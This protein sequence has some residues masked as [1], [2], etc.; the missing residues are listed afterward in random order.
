MPGDVWTLL[1]ML[2]AVV[3]ILAVAYWSTRLIA[4]RGLSVGAQSIKA[5]GELC[6]LAQINIGKGERLMLIRLHERCFLIGVT[7]ENISILTELTA[8]ES[9]VWL[10][11]A[12]QTDRTPSFIEALKST[13]SKKK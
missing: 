1:G 11:Q 2:A 7:T 4:R 5:T 6:V 8:E 10:S 3:A 13:I 9:A 12:E